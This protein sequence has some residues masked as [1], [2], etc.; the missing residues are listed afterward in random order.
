MLEEFADEW[1]N[2]WMFHYRWAR[3][4]DR[5]SAALKIVRMMKPGLDE[6]EAEI[7][8]MADQI[9]ERMVGRVWF[10]GSSEETAGQIE[11]GFQ[12]AMGQ[13]DDHLAER[14]YLLG[15]R[16]SFGDFGLFGQIYNAIT[17][18]TPGALVGARYQHVLAW[19]Q[20]MLWPCCDGEFEPWESLAPTLTPFLKDHVG[21]RF[22]PWTVANQNAIVAGEES[23]SVELAGQTW[24][25]KPQKYH[26]K[27]LET[28]R[29]RYA[30]ISDRKALDEILSSVDC[31]AAVVRPT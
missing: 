4:V 24:S 14:S 28:L 12:H 2:K 11:E 23:F 30:A 5:D 10:V 22:L 19:A 25:Q 27:S 3:P 21:A 13:L 15:E 29:D 17:D 18:P 9:A 6:P 7:T 8:A 31:L 26:A 1:A 20:R 16:P